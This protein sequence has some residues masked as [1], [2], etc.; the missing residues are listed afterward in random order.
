MAK[1][2]DHTCCLCK[3][4]VKTASIFHPQQRLNDTSQQIL[5]GGSHPHTCLTN[6][7][8]SRDTTTGSAIMLAACSL[9]ASI[10]R[11]CLR[12][13]QVPALAA[14]A[15]MAAYKKGASCA[16]SHPPSAVN[17]THPWLIL[18]MTYKQHPGPLLAD[19]V[20]AI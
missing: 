19:T 6:A 14:K 5:S 16:A 9:A 17:C 12:S 4:M 18:G 10:L 20:K 3:H 15:S 13:A 2:T 7:M 8:A 1:H 11:R